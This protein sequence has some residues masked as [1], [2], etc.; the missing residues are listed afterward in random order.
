MSQ[1]VRQTA[2]VYCTVLASNAH[3][4]LTARPAVTYTTTR[5]GKDKHYGAVAHKEG[6]RNTC[7]AYM[8]MGRSPTTCTTSSAVPVQRPQPAPRL[9]HALTGIVT[10]TRASYQALPQPLSLQ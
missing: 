9:M 8:A 5:T 1:L 6:Y 2:L 7:T 3:G 10:I 4:E